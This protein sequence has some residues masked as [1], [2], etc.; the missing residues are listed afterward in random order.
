[1]IGAS[2]ATGRAIP[3]ST[4][5]SITGPIPFCV[6]P[7]Y[8]KTGQDAGRKV[9][10]L[11]ETIRSRLRRAESIER[12]NSPHANL[13]VHSK[14]SRSIN[15][16]VL[17]NICWITIIFNALNPLQYACILIAVLLLV[18]ALPPSPG[19]DTARCSH[20]W[21]L[22]ERYKVYVVSY[23]QKNAED[24]LKLSQTAIGQEL[25]SVIDKQLAKRD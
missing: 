11:C 19:L 2:S 4:I 9:H 5:V 10:D 7:C 13:A 20:C 21:V 15:D 17:N 3:E 18:L 22:F 8:R 23:S 14:P 12:L 6:K 16:G 24:V 25:A 1:M